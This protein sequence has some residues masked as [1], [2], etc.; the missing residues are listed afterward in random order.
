[1]EAKS[2]TWLHPVSGEAV[3]TGHRKTPGEVSLN[4]CQVSPSSVMALVSAVMCWL[5][6]TYPL[7]G[8]KDILLR[9]RGALSSELNSLP[10]QDTLITT[11]EPTHNI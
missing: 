2:T 7:D 4:G 11:S 5:S 6:P 3:I 10:P 1:E 9:G 8:K